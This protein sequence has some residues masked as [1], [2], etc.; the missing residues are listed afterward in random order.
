MKKSEEEIKLINACLRFARENLSFARSGMKKD[1]TPFPTE[2]RRDKGQAQILLY[3]YRS[4][5][6]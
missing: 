1:F 2:E 6:K 5:G 3:S 4:P